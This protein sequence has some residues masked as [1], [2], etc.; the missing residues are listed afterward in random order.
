MD[1]FDLS[2]IGTPLLF[3]CGAVIF[4]IGWALGRMSKPG[5]DLTGPPAS[6]EPAGTIPDVPTRPRPQGLSLV[7]PAVPDLDP[8]TRSKI[9]ADLKRGR[10]VAA[11][12]TLREA[13]GLGLKDAKIAVE[14]LERG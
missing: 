7:A 9:D 1:G 14:E 4:M 3:L 2:S 11:I 12:K 10:K 13:T 5:T 6:G 8:A